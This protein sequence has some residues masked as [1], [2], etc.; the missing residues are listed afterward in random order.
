[1]NTN[2][3]QQDNQHGD[4]E[5]SSS[6]QSPYRVLA[7]DTSTAAL[8][9]AVMNND[10][11][12]AE[13]TVFAERNHS[14]YLTTTIAETLELAG[15]NKSELDGIAVGIGPGSYTG[16]RIAV[17]TAKTLAWALKLPV[18]GF[19]SL[20]A[21]ALG[22]WEH[23][24]TSIAE[25]KQSVPPRTS[26]LHWV[27]PLVDGRRGQV[28]TALFAGT[29][30]QLLR[31]METD[32]IRLM[33]DWSK[34]IAKWIQSAEPEERPTTVWFVGETE[35]HGVTAESELGSLLGEQLRI[36][37]YLLDGAPVGRVG[38][39][40]LQQG[41]SDDIH[42]LIPNYTQLSEAEANRLRNA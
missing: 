35:V 37:P 38:A 30:G 40:L 32:G 19:S 24:L 1:M 31:R 36:V 11:L 34:T 29:S 4:S 3:S 22:G 26:E 15:V 16:I 9:V 42:G 7:I 6:Q 20:E 17:T 8:A 27:I 2:D 18:A 5:L 13:K 21:L 41:A 23:G 12:L 39:D 14:V 10:Q 25:S 28:Y 33:V